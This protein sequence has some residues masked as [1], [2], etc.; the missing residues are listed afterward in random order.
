MMIPALTV[1]G[2]DEMSRQSGAH[3]A[4]TEHRS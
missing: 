1:S 3:R 2:W 4:L